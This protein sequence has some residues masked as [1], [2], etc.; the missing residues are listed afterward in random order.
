MP[1]AKENASKQNVTN[2]LKR[3]TIGAANNKDRRCVHNKHKRLA[4]VTNDDGPNRKRTVLGDVTNNTKTETIP[5]DKVDEKPAIEKSRNEK[6]CGEN[7]NPEKPLGTESTNIQVVRKSQRL[8]EKQH[9]SQ[10]SPNLTRDSLESTLESKE[11]FSTPSAESEET[12]FETPA[13]ECGTS[14]NLSASH[15]EHKVPVGVDDFDKELGNDP[16]SAPVYAQDIFTYFKS[17]EVKFK[18]EKYLDYQREITT[19]MRAVLI[20][21]MS[22]IQESFEMNHET[23]YLSVKLVDMYLSR[24]KFVPKANLQL[25]ATTA[26]MVAAKFD[27]RCAPP[28]ADFVYICDEAYS[29]NQL[30][31]TEINL[32]KCVDFDL[33]CPLSYTFLRRFARCSKQT[34]ETLTLARYILELSLMEYNLVDVLDSR[35]A[36]A[37]LAL[38]LQMLKLQPWTKTLEF[39]AGYKL[40]ELGDLLPK[41]NSL[42]RK[43]GKDG[44]QTIHTKYSHK[45]FYQVANK[46]AL[47]K[48]IIGLKIVNM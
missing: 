29:E 3:K 40:N 9:Q 38:A 6:Q 42:V 32:L 24:V 11:N 43:A 30:I 15:D 25:L 45:A 35:I 48:I 26:L 14:L 22:E 27:E 31:R 7:L 4:D 2:P 5:I 23:L 37:S 13:A 46:P 36:A 8:S 17:R 41:L 20:D 44:L 1:L 39:Y 28:I 19:H 16:F 33:G 34:M 10:L 18:V 12:K 21:W 47:E